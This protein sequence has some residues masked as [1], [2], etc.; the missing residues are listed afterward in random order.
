MN[1]STAA[2]EHE[3]DEHHLVLPGEV[4]H[5]AVADVAGDL[6]HQRVALVG[7]FHLVVEFQGEDQGHDGENR[8]DP[9]DVRNA[10]GR[11]KTR[12]YGFRCRRRILGQGHVGETSQRDQQ[13]EYEPPNLFQLLSFQDLISCYR[14]PSHTPRIG[15]RP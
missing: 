9:P 2:R 4:S 10:F 13:R 3:D 12:R 15:V 8:R 1:A 6:D 11:T 14:A 7:C 5:R